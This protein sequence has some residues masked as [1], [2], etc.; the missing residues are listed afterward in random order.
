MVGDSGWRRVGSTPALRA[1]AEAALPL[2]RRAIAESTEP[3]RCGGTWLVG[4]DALPN[5]QDGTIGDVALPWQDLGLEP[6]HLHPAQLSTVL[7]GYPQPSDTETPA[8]FAFRKNRG[9]AHLDGL[10]A[11][12]QGSRRIVEPH[13]WIL[14]LPLTACDAEAAPLTVWEGSADIL[15]EGLLEALEP[16]P[17]QSWGEVDVTEAYKVARQRCF[18]ECRRIDL[19]AQPGEAILLH[20]LTLHG[21]S[22]WAEGAAAPKEGRIIAYFRPLLPDAA[23]WLTEA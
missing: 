11:D 22:P 2:A 1:W 9:A 13:G 7:P 17:P 10:I 8:A 5:A 23:S 6:Q 20:R 16:Y 14:G 15:R 18:A 12:A 21:V 19:P 4:L 3:W